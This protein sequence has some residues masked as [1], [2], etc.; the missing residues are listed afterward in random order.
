MGLIPTQP[1]T[2]IKLEMSIELNI[3]LCIGTS[4]KISVY[5]F[6]YMLYTTYIDSHGAPI[7]VGPQATPQRA[8]AL[9]RH[10]RHM[11]RIKLIQ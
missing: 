2:G 4:D 10:C 1:L 3:N 5:T 6:K 8:H 9:I 7:F 11:S